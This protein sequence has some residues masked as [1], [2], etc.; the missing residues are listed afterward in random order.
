MLHQRSSSV[1]Y[2]HLREVRKCSV[3]GTVWDGLLP[4]SL[5][6][7]GLLSAVVL[8]PK[9]V[10]AHS[11]LIHLTILRLQLRR[12]V[13]S[14]VLK[15]AGCCF[16]PRKVVSRLKTVRRR[17]ESF[18]D[19]LV[20]QRVRKASRFDSIALMFGTWIYDELV[21]VSTCSKKRKRVDL[22]C[23]LRKR[24]FWTFSLESLFWNRAQLL[25]DYSWDVVPTLRLLYITLA[26]K[27]VNSNL[28]GP[29]QSG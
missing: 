29:R 11:N 19:N 22:A 8:V 28:V 5:S 7:F 10:Q 27:Y 20:F 21:N 24:H 3:I 17:R 13:R 4:L 15:T 23:I 6:I 2:S 18:V 26:T 14:D 12:I 1:S 25:N 16:S 9:W